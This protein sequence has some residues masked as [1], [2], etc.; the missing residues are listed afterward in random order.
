[1]PAHVELEEFVTPFSVEKAHA[2][3]L[4]AQQEWDWT[5]A[6]PGMRAARARDPK[7]LKVLELAS[8][9]LQQMEEDQRKDSRRT[10]EKFAETKETTELQMWR[11]AYNTA[12]RGDPCENLMWIYGAASCL[13]GFGRW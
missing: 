2:R 5:W 8:N 1:M 3:A 6:M 10:A 4:K 12:D 13:A 9:I 7:L 11:E